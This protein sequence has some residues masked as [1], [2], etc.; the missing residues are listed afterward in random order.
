MTASR[1]GLLLPVLG[2]LAIPASL[3]FSPSAQND[4]A[5][6]AAIT[7]IE[8]DGVTADLAG[9]ASFSEKNL[10]D[11]WTGGTSRGT[12]DTK[13]SLIADIK[14]TNNNKMNSESLSALKVRVHGDVAVA[15]YTTTY[16]GMIKGQHYARTIISTDVFQQTGGAWKIIAGHSSLVANK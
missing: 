4:A 11:D 6:V 7:K 13:A 15:T 12:W 2:A 16:D 8:N 10:A 3:A 14:D 9:D 1:V 5:A